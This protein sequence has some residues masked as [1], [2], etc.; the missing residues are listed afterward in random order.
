MTDEERKAAY[1][2]VAKHALERGVI[3]QAQY[4]GLQIVR[5][6]DYAKFAVTPTHDTILADVKQATYAAK[7]EQARTQWGIPCINSDTISSES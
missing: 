7:R 4:D 2:K 3:T 1:I 5:L 6:P